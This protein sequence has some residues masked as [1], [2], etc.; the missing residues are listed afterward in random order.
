MSRSASVDNKTVQQDG[1]AKRG[2][3]RQNTRLGRK[4][5][6]RADDQIK[7]KSE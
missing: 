7:G 2:K 3:V 4:Q 5:A 1:P 6:S